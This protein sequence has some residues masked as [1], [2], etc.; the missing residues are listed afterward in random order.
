N[1]FQP[2]IRRDAGD[3]P[4]GATDGSEGLGVNDGHDSS[5]V[6]FR[7]FSARGGDTVPGTGLLLSKTPWIGLD[8]NGGKFGFYS[9]NDGKVSNL[10]ATAV[11]SGSVYPNDMQVGI[12]ASKGSASAVSTI[13]LDSVVVSPALLAPAAITGVSYLPRDKSVIVAWNPAAVTGA[14]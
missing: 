13:K 8:R 9:S 4:Q 5:L 10:T 6:G 11:D 1:L 12:E 2:E 14:D 3:T 7:G